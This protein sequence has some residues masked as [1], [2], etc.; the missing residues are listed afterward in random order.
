MN[1][2]QRIETD[3]V[4]IDFV[5]DCGGSISLFQFY[6][7][8]EWVD[9]L[10]QAEPNCLGEND[11]LASSSFVLLPFSN[12]IANGIFEFEGKEYQIA[13]NMPPEPHAIHGSSWQK[14]AILTEYSKNSVK[15]IHQQT[16]D[17]YP[18]H[19]S[20]AQTWVIDDDGCVTVDL[21]IANTSTKPMPFGMGIHPY[22]VKTSNC[23]IIANTQNV[24]LNDDEMV[25]V[26][27]TP[28]PDEWDFSKGLIPAKSQMDNCYLG[29][30]RECQIKW[31]E[32]KTVLDISASDVFNNM[33]VYIPPNDPFFCLEPVSNI[34]DAYNNGLDLPDTGLA[35]L[36]AGETLEG[37]IRLK[38][39]L[40]P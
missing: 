33:V 27:V 15:I 32:L 39:S 25:P 1:K 8:D 36:V 34:N 17:D 18:F 30:D 7:G 31:P 35:T 3:K 26:S 28:T 5:P 20:A 2:T 24:I 21:K 19:F 10:R 6:N 4:R 12:R 29:W 11:P 22:F 37:Q 40:A 14:P 23:T 9:I 13:P 38:L 16:S